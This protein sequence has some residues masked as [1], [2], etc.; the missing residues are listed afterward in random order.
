[1][2]AAFNAK[3]SSASWNHGRT[4]TIPYPFENLTLYIPPIRIATLPIASF[5]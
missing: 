5:G 4:S 3:S 1:V 2:I